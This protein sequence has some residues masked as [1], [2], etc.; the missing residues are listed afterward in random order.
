MGWERGTHEKKRQT[1]RIHDF[2]KVTRRKGPD[3]KSY[4]RT[5][6]KG[7]MIIEHTN[8]IWSLEHRDIATDLKIRI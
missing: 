2:G 4:A 3:C 5:E 6:Q 8:E 1:H 7:T